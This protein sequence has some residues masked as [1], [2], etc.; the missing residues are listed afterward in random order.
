MILAKLHFSYEIAPQKQHF[1]YK[2]APQKLHFSFFREVLGAAQ[3]CS[4]M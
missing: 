2:T 4:I 3:Q 1:S